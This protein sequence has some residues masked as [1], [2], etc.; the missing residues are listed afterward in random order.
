MKKR[1]SFLKKKINFPKLS[2]LQ[3]LVWI[4]IFFIPLWPKL[5]FKNINYT[6]VAIRY[7]DLFVAFIVLVFALNLLFKRIKLP[8]NPFNKLIPMYWIVV[9]VSA[10][11]G[12]YYFKS[13]ESLQLVMLHA[14][15]RVEYMI[16]FF[17]GLTSI[18]N[19]KQFK[20]YLNSLIL[21]LFIISVYGIGQKF[22]GWPA[23][24]TMNPH[25]SKGYILTLDANARVSS[26]FGG[27]YDFAAFLVFM[28]PLALGLFLYFQKLRYFLVFTVALI[29]LILT[30][31]RA[32]YIAYL[33]TVPLFILLLKRYR[34]L[35]VVIALTIVLTP[36][37][38]TLTKRINRT[39]RQ[40]LVWVN[41]DSGRAIVPR[42]ITASDLP[43]GDYIIKNKG[44]KLKQTDEQV[45]LV[46]RE[47]KETIIKKA[48]QQGKELTND[49]VDV[50]V[51]QAFAN[52]DPISTVLPDIS[53]ATRLQVEW[54]RAI[55]AFLKNP[56][57]GTGVASITEATDNDYLRALGETGIL[58]FGLL[59]LIM[60]KLQLY[61]WQKGRQHK[62][63]QA[64]FWGVLFGSIALMINALYI[65][66]FEASKVALMIWLIW[67]LVYKLNFFAKNEIK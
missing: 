57:T 40:E 28:M 4:Y 9:I 31:S 3:F 62:T 43:A 33:L 48:K 65:D 12:F 52:F 14:F 21:M 55:S 54:P 66:V 18:N 35:L 6:Y 53:F 15:R 67:G 63:Y 38:D 36:L 45:M 39:F 49:E 29:A 25:Y 58:G 59:M 11:I 30:A 27:H 22:W 44:K 24:Q 37:S 64:V 56:L 7:E 5:P 2:F 32:S 61:L 8:Q 60:L 46:K 51:N 23:V 16:V 17:I 20:F 41:P 50:L 10:L 34:L 19:T 47:I 42:N 13:A 26:T 1:I